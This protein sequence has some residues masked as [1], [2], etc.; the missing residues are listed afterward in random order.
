[1]AKATQLYPHIYPD[2]PDNSKFK[3]GTGW[4]KRF[5]DRHGVRSL[6]MQG[7]SMSAA[8]MDVE[9][10]KKKFQELVEESGL[11]REQV[12][13]CD[14]SGLYWKLMPNKTLVTSREK[15]AKAFKKPKDRVTIMACANASG[16]IK[17]PLVFIHKFAN[18]RCFKNI[19]KNDLP[20]QYFHQRNA[21]M[22]STIFTNWFKNCFVPL[23]RKALREKQKAFLL[24]DNAPSH[25]DLSELTSEDGQIRC[26]YLPPNTTSVLQ[27]MDQGVLETIKKRYKRDLLLRLLDEGDSDSNIADFR[28]KLNIKDAVLMAANSWSN[29]KQQTIAKSWKKLWPEW[30]R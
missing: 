21:W 23:C 19:D 15:E 16:T 12:F 2:D 1:M 10:F 6:S 20:V 24:L 9:P 11:S 30:R 22:D 4:L 27:P 8:I 18:P 14:E 5:R 26:V 17:L 28:K 25:P 13:N 29:V 3:G 7:E